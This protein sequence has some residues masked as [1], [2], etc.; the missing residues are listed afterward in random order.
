MAVRRPLYT[1]SNNLREMSDSQITDLITM[2]YWKYIENPSVTLSVIG[3]NGNIPNSLE[4]E[5]NPNG[6][7]DTRQ[8]ASAY[9]T[10]KSKFQAVNTGTLNVLQNKLNQSFQVAPPADD[11]E[12]VAFPL[13]YTEDSKL[14]AMSIQD[15]LDTF[16]TPCLALLTAGDDIYSISPSLTK[17]GYNLVS[18]ISLFEDTGSNAA[19]YLRIY[20]ELIDEGEDR[21]PVAP[22]DIPL[23]EALDNFYLFRRDASGASYSYTNP[24]QFVDTSSTTKRFNTYNDSTLETLFSNIIRNSA[25]DRDGYKIR[26]TWDGDGGASGTVLDQKLN[27]DTDGEVREWRRNANDYRSQAFPNGDFEIANTY[28]LRVGVV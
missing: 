5:D 22:R 15:M 6:I 21:I 1:E 27:G 23:D 14:R 3:S 11:I 18:E 16:V 8:V 2:M 7:F 28:I 19:E 10:N 20:Q 4:D 26:Y 9:K 17:A 24:V 25:R 12:S 13:Y